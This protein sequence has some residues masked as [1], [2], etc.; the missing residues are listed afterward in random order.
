[1]RISNQRPGSNV[2]LSLWVVNDLT[3][4]DNVAQN[5]II[6][7]TIYDSNGR[8]TL[9]TRDLQ[10]LYN[11]TPAETRVCQLLYEGRNLADIAGRLGVTKHT[12]KAHLSHSFKKVGVTNQAHLLRKLSL[13]I[14]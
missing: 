7:A 9:R 13:S 10:A 12:V 8:Y 2:H 4:T 1:M 3:E 5:R 6:I 14:G 11:F